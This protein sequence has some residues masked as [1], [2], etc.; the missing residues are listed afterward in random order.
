MLTSE[1]TWLEIAELRKDLVLVPIGS[2]EQ[3]GPHL[4]LGTD[5]FIATTIAQQVGKRLDA[6]VLPCIPISCSQEHHG[7]PG[8]VWLRPT[9]LALVIEDIVSSLYEDGIRC[10]ALLNQHGGN[11]VLKSVVLDLNRKF[12]GLKL[13]LFRATLLTPEVEQILQ[14]PS[15]SDIHAGELETSLMMSIAPNL[16]RRSLA[17]NF[18]PEEDFNYVEYVGMKRLIP[19]GVW[20][21]SDLATAEKGDRLLEL[22][23]DQLAKAI[24]ETYLQIQKL[25]EV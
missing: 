15:K 10:I 4:P 8:V 3:H 14:T 11:S 9:T 25:E 12:H 6:F 18:I 17:V 23:V 24:Q 1:H 21:N 22:I 20:G 7:F 13:T 16:V 5:T 19:M 2:L